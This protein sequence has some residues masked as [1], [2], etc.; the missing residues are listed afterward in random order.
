MSLGCSTTL[1]TSNTEDKP[2]KSE[3]KWFFQAR[4]I[5]PAKL[6]ITHDGRIG[7]FRYTRSQ[8]IHLSATL[9][10]KLLNDVLH[11]NEEIN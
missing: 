9:L 10:R 2:S 11:Q 3:G 6:S 1:E 4:M 7:I 5:H 8:P